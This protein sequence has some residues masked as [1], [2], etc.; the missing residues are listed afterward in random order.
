V[1]LIL[2]DAT[3]L[4]YTSLSSVVDQ[5]GQ[6]GD[7]THRG[8][9][10]HNSLVV[11]AEPQLVIGLGSQILHH[12]ADVP[13]NETVKEARE[14]TSRESLLWLK[15]ASQCGPTPPGVFCVDVSD[16]LSDTFEYMSYEIASERRFVLRSRE[17]RK[18]AAPVNGKRYLYEAV[19]KQRAVATRTV[20]VQ[21]TDKQLERQAKVSISFVEVNLALP[22]KQSGC[23]KPRSLTV[24][25][26]RVWVPHPP[27]GADALEW[28][29]LT[30]VP[31]AVTADAEQRVD[32]YE[33]RPIVEEYHK[34]Q[35]TGCGIETFQFTDVTRLE[36][37][38]ALISSVA[39]TLLRL[40]D[41]ARQPDADVRPANELFAQEYIDVLQKPCAARTPA[42][43][44]VRKFLLAVARL[45]GHQNRKCDG[46][47]GWITLWRGWMKL[48]LQVT[49]YRIA[50]HR[51]VAQTKRCGKT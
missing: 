12:R 51:N 19:R 13:E 40:R 17:N 28:I 21:G 32:W 22:G 44:T 45:G 2:H 14:R 9:I 8:F 48:E 35:K 42:P 29:L 27:A 23:Y 41:V 4:D 25:A 26:V 38:I 43:M 10:C 7:G 49:G 1:F 18:L 50:M 39:T 3:E 20:F 16:S 11:Q 46:M 31:V 5:L 37:A 34:A 30:N 15:G 24:W 6:I 47:P 36:P 33:C